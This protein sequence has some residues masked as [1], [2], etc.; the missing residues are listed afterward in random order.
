MKRKIIN[1]GVFGAAAFLFL[2]AFSSPTAADDLADLALV[3][4]GRARAVTSAHPDPNSNKDRVGIVKPGETVILADIKGP[5]VINHIWL[6]F[7]EARP[8]WLEAAG[9]ARPDEIALRI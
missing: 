9:S 8:N 4:P 1:A 2:A 6:T 5:A 7:N 3:K